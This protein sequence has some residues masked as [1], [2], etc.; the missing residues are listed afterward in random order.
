MT[1]STGYY[2]GP[3]GGVRPAKPPRADTVVSGCYFPFACPYDMVSVFRGNGDGTFQAP[4]SFFPGSNNGVG[5][6]AIA[7]GDFDGDGTT[8]LVIPNVSGT[9]GVFLNNGDG[10]FGT[11]KNPSVNFNPGGVVVTDLNGDGKPDIV[12]SG[13][14]T[15][16]V[17]LGNGDGTFATPVIYSEIVGYG[18][19]IAAAD[20]NG[21]GKA[22]IV[23]APSG[24]FSS[25]PPRKW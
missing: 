11:G 16:A 1:F 24:Q 19:G 5:S 13:Y 18:G 20:M 21:D 10:T 22:D 25:R 3:I 12:L 14:N 2:N 23:L 6:T 7:T 17:L 9:I 4:L 15:V 8:D